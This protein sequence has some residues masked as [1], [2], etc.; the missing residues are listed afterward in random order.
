LKS[1]GRAVA[2]RQSTKTQ[3]KNKPKEITMSTQ[4]QIFAN[5]ANAQKSTGPTS[6]AGKETSSHNRTTHGLSDLDNVFFLHDFEDE[7]QFE[8]LKANLCHEH[9]P[10]TETEKLLVRRLAESE[11][12]RRRAL[13]FQKLCQNPKTGYLEQEKHFAL[14]LRYQAIHERA[15]YKALNELQKLRNERRNRQIGFE[16]QK[17]NAAADQRSAAA[18]NRA[19]ELHNLKKQEFEL[20]N[21]RAARPDPAKK[22]AAEPSAAAP[23]PKTS[24]GDLEMAA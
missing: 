24:P 23:I 8:A 2:A 4:A 13:H 15:F 3:L 20:K 11:W 22:T 1:S 16:S 18:E 6:N 9:Q 17:R 19:A 21:Q 12:L 5:Q 14:Y 10:Q 7:D